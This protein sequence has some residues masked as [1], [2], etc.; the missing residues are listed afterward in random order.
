MVSASART[1]GTRARTA[2]VSWRQ[3]GHGQALQ[4]VGEQAGLADPF[5]HGQRV[6][7]VVLG[8]G[9]VAVQQQEPGQEERGVADVL[10][11]GLQCRGQAAARIVQVGL[12]HQEPVLRHPRHGQVKVVAVLPDRRAPVEH[13]AGRRQ[14]G[15][16]LLQPGVRCCTGRPGR[17]PSAPATPR[18]WPRPSPPGSRRAG[19]RRRRRRPRPPRS[20]YRT[21]P[22]APAGSAGAPGGACH[23]RGRRAGRPGTPPWP[24]APPGAPEH[25]GQLGLHSTAA[26]VLARD[27]QAE[28]KEEMASSLAKDAVAW[29]P[30]I[31]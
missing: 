17:R 20:G 18:R 15:Q 7:Q 14:R 6:L 1:R 13:R 28:R 2:A 9:Q 30:A 31:S 23:R 10:L 3:R 8:L 12:V 27:L 16:G 22:A 21:P 24:G 19:P 26:V 25:V 11:L 4:A 29:S 5:G